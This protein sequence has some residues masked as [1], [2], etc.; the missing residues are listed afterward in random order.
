MDLV[1]A[2]CALLLTV[3]ASA[4]ATTYEFGGSNAGAIGGFGRDLTFNVFGIEESIVDARLEL[5]LDYSEARELGFTLSDPLSAVQL[6]VAGFSALPAGVG[7]HGR[8]RFD[9]R[10]TTAWTELVAPNGE[11][12]TLVPARA[13]QVGLPG[14]VCFN[15][16]ARYLEHDFDERNGERRLQVRR[17]ASGPGSGSITAARLI[18]DTAPA[19]LLFATGVEEPA[20]PTR[21]CRRAPLDLAFHSGADF[22]A[23][24][25]LALS[26]RDAKNSLNWSSL[27]LSPLQDFGPFVFGDLSAKAY[28]GRFGWRSRLNM[29]VWNEASGTLDFT[30]GPT[31]GAGL[32]TLSL[33]G[34]WT[35]RTYRVIPGD[36]DGDGATDVAVAFVADNNQWKARIRFSRD[37]TIADFVV[38]PRVLR[39]AEFS[40]VEIGF[41]PAQDADNNGTDEVTLFARMSPASGQMAMMRIDLLPL[42]NGAV[43]PVVQTVPWGNIGDRLVLGK[44]TAA[45]DQLG[46]MV[47]RF[48]GGTW[49]WFRLGNPVPTVWG[50][51]GDYPVSFDG[52]GD[53]LNDIAYYR[54]SDHRWHLIRSSDQVQTTLG[55]WGDLNYEPLGYSLGT[56]TPGAF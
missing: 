3:G 29:G 15:L 27:Q 51:L 38:D 19:D 16:L 39:P 56:V 11:V 36:Y 55:P 21:R 42:L 20:V 45:T 18:I 32:R 34:D 50:Q 48:A 10:S 43:A 14:T 31:A 2:C 30:T 35:S 49:Q 53:G 33:P 13:G 17:I 6:P 7:V 24:S 23:V 9:D 47:V 5:T 46:M 26:F 1:K 28:A 8:Y 25:P 4:S 54:R 12:S 40:S 41:G 44:W 37:E 22:N 52:D